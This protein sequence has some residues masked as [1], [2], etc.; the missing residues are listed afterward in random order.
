MFEYSQFE[1]RSDWSSTESRELPRQWILA[2][3]SWKSASTFFP[4][5]RAKRAT[6]ALEAE[7]GTVGAPKAPC[8]DVQFLGTW[9]DPGAALAHHCF[10]RFVAFPIILTI[11]EAFINTVNFPVILS[12]ALS[13]CVDVGRV[14]L[15]ENLAE[16]VKSFG[17][18]LIQLLPTAPNI[19][20]NNSQN[21]K[22]LIR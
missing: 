1:D 6:F 5:A 4:S 9:W 12:E 10:D 20:I 18:L 13:A 22:V 21:S 17:M 7:M 3:P 14:G 15:V 2:N 16:A 8:C 19:H 11:L